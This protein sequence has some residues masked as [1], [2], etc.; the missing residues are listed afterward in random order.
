[1]GEKASCA[2]KVTWIG[3]VQ[4]V[5]SQ[6]AASAVALRFRTTGGVVST[7][8]RS[9]TFSP[10]SASAGVWEGASEA[11]TLTWYPP[12]GIRVASK[13]YA[14]SVILSLRRRHT[15]SPSPRR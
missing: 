5:P 15:D 2:S 6:L 3:L 8:K 10:E 9:L 14:L 12:S 7:S 1:M 13:L 11:T 4:W